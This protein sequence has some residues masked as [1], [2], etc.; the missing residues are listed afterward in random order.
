MALFIITLRIITILITLNTGD[1][2][3]NGIT[4][5]TNKCNISYMVFMCT[6]I[7][8]VIKGKFSYKLSHYGQSLCHSVSNLI[9]VFSLL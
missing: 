7:S 4:K 2:H 1:I 3:L 8:E 5:N 9:H 6:V